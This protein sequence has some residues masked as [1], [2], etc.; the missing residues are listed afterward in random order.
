MTKIL[1][2]AEKFESEENDISP[3]DLHTQYVQNLQE[4]I[5]ELVQLA[6]FISFIPIALVNKENLKNAHF[7]LERVNKDLETIKHILNRSG[8]Y[9][10]YR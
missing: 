8:I 3:G 5:N 2:L 6:E 7:R 10:Q 9:K 1:K 4:Q